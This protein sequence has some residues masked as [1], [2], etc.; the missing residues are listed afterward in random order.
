[1]FALG[2][3]PAPDEDQARTWRELADANAINMLSPRVGT[4]VVDDA[5]RDEWAAEI[6]VMLRSLAHPG[7][8][9][10]GRGPLRKELENAAR[11]D[12]LL[13]SPSRVH[14]AA[15]LV[16]SAKI[17]GTSASENL[18]RALAQR[19]EI[20]NVATELHFATE[21]VHTGKAETMAASI[22]KA[23]LFVLVTPLYIDALPALVVRALDSVVHARAASPPGMFAT[24]INCGFP[25][26]EHTRTA[27]RI[28]H[29]F[30]SAG[31]Y[32]WAGGLPLGGGGY[33]KPKVPLDAQHGPAIHV[34]RALD[35]AAPALAAGDNVPE[36][37]LVR[38][39]ESPM[40]DFVYRLIADLGWRYQVHQHGL[41]QRELRARPL[42]H[43]ASP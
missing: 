7:V 39:M 33:I 22:A 3:M 12:P 30:A 5:H 20:E 25:E 21:F 17:K 28:T 38:M 11:P 8:N 40:P 27:M 41:A 32:H 29:H 37:A 15:L 19:L 42:D 18:A 1:M 24:I 14:T 31:A 2:W 16:G 26:P 13:A 10:H 23:D 36:L 43:P 4:A 35:A 6:C 9:I 34:R